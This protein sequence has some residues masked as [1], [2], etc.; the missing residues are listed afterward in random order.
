MVSGGMADE[1]LA[2][3]SFFE[4]IYCSSFG[5]LNSFPRVKDDIDHIHEQG[6]HSVVSDGQRLVP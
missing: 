5:F 6:L 2:P 4:S 3:V 1:R